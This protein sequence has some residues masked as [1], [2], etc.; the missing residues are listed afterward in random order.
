MIEKI[1]TQ[2]I[3]ALRQLNWSE[4]TTVE[5][6][7]T[8]NPEHGD[9]SSNVAMTLASKLKIRPMEIA[10]KIQQHISHPEI[11]RVD[12]ASPGF[13]NFFTTE[14]FTNLIKTIISQ[15]QSFFH[16]NIGENN[17]IHLEY[18]SA[19]PTGPLHVG[20]GRSAAYGSS[21][22]NILKAT[23]FKVH[24]EYYVNNAGLQI[25]ILST[26]LWLRTLGITP[27]L[28][29]Y[30][31]EYLVDIAANSTLKSN[32]PKTLEPLLNKWS[33][34]NKASCLSELVLICKKE[35]GTKFNDLKIWVTEQITGQI[36]DDLTKFGVHYDQWFLESS[37]VDDGRVEAM[38]S[39]LTEQDFTYEK[40][41]ALWF[42]SSELGDEKDRVL[43]RSNG[44]WTYFAID[45]AYH[46]QKS[47]SHPWKII[48]IFGADHH[49]YVPRVK[50]GLSALK[51]DDT[52][53]EVRLIQFANLYR[54]EERIPM[55]TRQGQFVTLSD[56]Y[57]EVGIDATR[58]FYCMRRSDQHLDFDL[59]LA[60]SQ[61]SQ[62]PVYYIQYAYA[63][64]Q[65]VL[66]KHG[67]YIPS[68]NHFKQPS[69]LEAEI[70]TLLSEYPSTLIK[71][72]ESSEVYRWAQYCYKIALLFH[73]YYNQTTILAEDNT[74][75]YHR[76]M[77][78][79]LVSACLK[80]SLKLIGINTPRHM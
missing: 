50:A 35:L 67:Q 77:I 16:P 1:E 48:D 47:A 75:R 3:A 65:S 36:R 42:K 23:G 5:V 51:Q 60:K 19:N 59:E 62:N 12:V 30:T 25:D 11:T 9:F 24:T 57:S 69:D 38:I 39:H 52:N 55:S 27:P 26:S 79:H 14:D 15:E 43:K 44:I 34:D 21:L 74:T 2:I 78:C 80:S 22:A 68:E 31:G 49:G 32:Q 18:V 29:C 70:L 76:L 7:K 53:F 61:S 63:R 4:L 66:E 54:G 37:L 72:A 40:E 41:N 10:R 45:L 20:H 33:E 13:L 46:H 56:L 28:G 64:I 73:R 71:T 58:Y 6:S 17:L 8:K